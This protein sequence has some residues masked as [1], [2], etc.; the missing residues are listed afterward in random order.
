MVGTRGVISDVVQS[1]RAVD[2]RGWQ[3][4]PR[5]LFDAIVRKAFARRSTGWIREQV[6]R[7]GS[8][9]QIRGVELR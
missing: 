4:S 7:H 5:V 3:S 2:I 8:A 1:V 9:D 6:D